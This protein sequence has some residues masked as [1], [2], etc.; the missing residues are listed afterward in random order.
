ML[1]KMITPKI[2]EFEAFTLEVRLDLEKSSN[3]MIIAVSAI[4]SLF[5]ALSQL[6]NYI[7]R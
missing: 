5:L 3:K 4:L 1:I 7:T 6:L 2:T